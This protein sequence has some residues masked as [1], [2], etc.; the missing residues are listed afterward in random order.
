MEIKHE[1]NEKAATQRANLRRA[2]E[3]RAGMSNTENDVLRL[4]TVARWCADESAC[5]GN[6]VWTCATVSA[7]KPWRRFKK[8]FCGT[9]GLLRWGNTHGP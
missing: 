9:S 2:A 4:Y 1:R 3:N 8:T 7:T 5:C 6:V